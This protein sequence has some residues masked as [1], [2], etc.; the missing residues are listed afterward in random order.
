MS[1][2][3]VTAQKP[4]FGVGSGCQW[5]GSC[6]RSVRNAQ[7]GTSSTKKSWFARSISSSR[8]AISISSIDIE[9]ERK[10]VLDQRW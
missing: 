4:G 2:N 6:S 10:V 8:S 5:T 7:W 1:W 3:R 9:E